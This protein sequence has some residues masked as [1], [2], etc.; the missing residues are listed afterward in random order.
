MSA[1][2]KSCGIA[3]KKL[4]CLHFEDDLVGK[5]PPDPLLG[6]VSDG[7]LDRPKSCRTM[8]N[9]SLTAFDPNSSCSLKDVLE[10]REAKW[11]ATDEF[12]HLEV[13]LLAGMSGEQGESIMISKLFDLMP[14]ATDGAPGTS[15]K[16]CNTGL[17]ALVAS[18]LSS[19]VSD[20]CRGYCKTAAGIVADMSAGEKLSFRKGCVAAPV[21]KCLDRLLFLCQFNQKKPK[22]VLYAKPEVDQLYADLQ[23]L[24]KEGDPIKSGLSCESIHSLQLY[25]WVCDLACTTLVK[26]ASDLIK[27][28]KAGE[29]G[30]E[31]SLKKVKAAGGAAS[32]AS[33]SGPSK[34]ELL[35]S[36][37]MSRY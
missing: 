29:D 23:V 6:D 35:R 5:H 32:S 13:S 20:T 10:N 31:P 18:P 27:A 1:H 21:Q 14:A 11:G 26:Q 4:H 25:W 24:M 19:F 30:E 2:I 12:V 3:R 17:Q 33:S 9:M 34:Q 37:V 16:D 8:M 36:S 22:R 15:L 7:L 28:S